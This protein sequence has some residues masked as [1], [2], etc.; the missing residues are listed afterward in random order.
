[1]DSDY[2]DLGT[3]DGL[4]GFEGAIGKI[5]RA[6]NQLEGLNERF[7]KFAEAKPYHCVE[8]FDARPDEPSSGV[9]RYVVDSVSLPKREW[10]V[11][12]GELVHNLR[13]ALDHSIYAAAKRPSRTN[14]FPIFTDYCDWKVKSKSMLRTVPKKIADLVEERQPYHTVAPERP[15]HHLLTVLNR[16]SNHDKHRLLHTTVAAVTGIKEPRFEKGRDVSAITGAEVVLGPLKPGADLARVQVIVSGPEPD[17]KMY[18]EFAIDVTLAD[19]LGRGRVTE[20]AAV[21]P[22]LFALLQYVEDIV[23]RIEAAAKGVI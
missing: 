5:V 1:M 23:I 7:R 3:Y 8:Q 18:G 20:G 15:D 21:M 19:P 14:Q 11:L 10:G 6:K 9:Y 13:S 4:S 22:L 17:V 2:K 16:L 12:I